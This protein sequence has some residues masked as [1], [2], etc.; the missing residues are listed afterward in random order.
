MDRVFLDANVLFSAAWSLG[1]IV[2]RLWTFP[3]SAVEFITSD[4]AANEATRNLSAAAR[5]RLAPLLARVSM[6]PTP[7]PQDWL[8]LPGI[9]LPAKDHPILQAAIA[10]RATHLL[11]GDKKH[12][13]PYY[14]QTIEGVLILPPSRYEPSGA[15]VGDEQAGGDVF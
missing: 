3:P 14:G 11:T 2:R 10:A 5:T 15:D 12:F 6:V 13:G 8:P 9:V 1:A 4:Y 7:S